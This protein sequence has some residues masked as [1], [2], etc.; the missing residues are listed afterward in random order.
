MGHPRPP[1]RVRD[2]APPCSNLIRRLELDLPYPVSVGSYLRSPADGEPSRSRSS[3]SNRC[4]GRS[5]SRT[6]LLNRSG[7]DS[8]PGNRV[9]GGIGSGTEDP[10]VSLISTPLEVSRQFL[11][12]VHRFFTGP[13]GR[14]GALPGS[15]AGEPPSYRKISEPFLPSGAAAARPKALRDGYNHAVPTYVT[16]GAA[17]C[18]SAETGH[19]VKSRYPCR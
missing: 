2:A 16:A 7:P 19:S 14:H 17:K 9:G 13:N 5:S 11:A 4:M 10:C 15:D 3:S 18:S 1:T 8:N 12:A 6:T